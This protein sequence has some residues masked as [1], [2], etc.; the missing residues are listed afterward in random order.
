MNKVPISNQMCIMECFKK[1]RVEC[2]FSPNTKEDNQLNIC[3]PDKG[4][5][6][7]FLK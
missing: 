2:Y 3:E 5:S 6:L 1:S 7:V 4:T